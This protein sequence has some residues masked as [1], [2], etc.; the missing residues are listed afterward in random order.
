MLKGV[1]A[2]GFAAALEEEEEEVG[3][4]EEEE[5]EEEEVEAKEVSEDDDDVENVVWLEE[6]SMSVVMV[7][8]VDAEPP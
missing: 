7:E 3:E 1:I 8:T 5:E 6:T 4:E 2:S